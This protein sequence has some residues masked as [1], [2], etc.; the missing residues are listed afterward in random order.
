MLSVSA[1]N[2]ADMLERQ[3]IEIMVALIVH[4]PDGLERI[5]A[6]YCDLVEVGQALTVDASD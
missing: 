3:L 5:E 4:H 1:M 2:T 6:V